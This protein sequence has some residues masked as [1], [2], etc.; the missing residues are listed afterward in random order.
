MI[1]TRFDKDNTQTLLLQRSAQGILNGDINA[2][3]TIKRLRHTHTRSQ[4]TIAFECGFYALAEP[5]CIVKSLR[6]HHFVRCTLFMIRF[7]FIISFS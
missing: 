6:F 7:Q 2:A 1:S 3:S 4:R 5:F